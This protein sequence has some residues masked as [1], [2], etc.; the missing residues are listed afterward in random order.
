MIKSITNIWT[1]V[2]ILSVFFYCSL[3]NAH[4]NVALEQDNCVRNMGGSMVH[5]STYQPQYDPEA[6]YCTEI[7][8]NGKTLW[9]LDLID[10]ALRDMPINIQI[11]RASGEAINETVASL[12]SVN[13]ID[14][15][16]KGESDL[17]EGLYTVYITGEGIPPVHY[18]FPLRVQMINYVDAF[19]TAVVP[20]IVL[21]LLTLFTRKF[22]RLRQLKL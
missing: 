22:L 15:V 18:E 2:F 8:K 17:D 5:L 20:I 21:L 11:V 3:A 6:E 12:R 19:S 1:T 10:H 7:P 16:I 14:G 13:H 9:V 4:G